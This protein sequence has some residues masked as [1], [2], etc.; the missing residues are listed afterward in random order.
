MSL[1]VKAAGQQSYFLKEV[2]NKIFP[3]FFNIFQ[4]SLT[5]ELHLIMTWK[6][7]LI[8]PVNTYKKGNKNDPANYHPLSLMCMF[9]HL[10]HHQDEQSTT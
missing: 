2:A 4:A 10:S 7:A 8:A 5:K 1:A 9:D 3:A 6:S